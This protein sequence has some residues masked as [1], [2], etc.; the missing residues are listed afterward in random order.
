MA[1]PSARR[2]LIVDDEVPIADSLALIFRHSGYEAVA[3]YSATGALEACASFTPDLLITDVTMPGVNGIELAIVIRQR[4]PGCRILL[5]SGLAAS[6]LLVEQAR[7]RG[8]DFELL[9]KPVPPGELL[10]RV[11]AAF[12]GRSLLEFPKNGL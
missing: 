5:L 3:R 8:H 10:Q 6:Y 4:C 1:K 2:I 9:E 7:T 12:T 11:S